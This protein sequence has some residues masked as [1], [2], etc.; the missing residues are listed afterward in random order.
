MEMKYDENFVNGNPILKSGQVYRDF[1]D[2]RIIYI[3]SD[4]IVLINEEDHIKIKINT[5]EIKTPGKSLLNYYLLLE[6]LEKELVIAYDK[7]LGYLSTLPTNLGSAT[8]FKLKIKLTDSHHSEILNQLSKI[9]DEANLTITKE[10]EIY[11]LNISNKTSFYN[12]ANLLVEII[13][14]KDYLK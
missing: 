10:N 6:E 5:K 3:N 7:D 1:P 4:L 12:L 8:F 13:S 11:Y 14:I 2:D 9:K